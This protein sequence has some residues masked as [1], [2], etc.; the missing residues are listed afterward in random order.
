LA[1]LAGRAWIWLKWPAAVGILAWLYL[2]NQAAL[3]RVA[4]A[5][6]SWGYLGGAILLIYGS[7][8]LTFLRWYLLVRAQ[9]FPF[10]V[11]DAVRLGFLGLICNYVAPGSVGGDIFKA[12]LL[13]RSQQA[14]RAVAVA[15]VLLDRVLG[16]LAL[17]MVGSLATLLPLGIPDHHEL[18]FATLALW[19]GTLIGL[20]GMAFMLLPV[21]SRAR[22]VGRL[23][24]L[25]LVGHWLD[26]LIHGVELYQK[27]PLVL[28]QALV[29][30]LLGHAGLIAG[31]YLCG[32][33]MRQSWIPSLA[34]HYYFM[35]NAELFG[36][37]VPVPGGVG[38]LEGAIQWFYERLRPQTVSASE[39][40]AAGFMAAM[41]FRLVTVGIAAAG[42]GYYLTARQELARAIEESQGRD[43][44]A[45]SVR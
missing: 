3:A 32:L 20:A 40:M 37:L 27:R 13:A 8:L 2:S 28:A 45:Q 21:L 42:G 11:R 43:P 25:P 6:K 35:P 1:Q 5:P 33:W 38:A 15:T 23:T 10:L 26:E 9:D 31:F 41:A 12:L 17:F 7:T 22:W 36:V 4:A 18:R 30:S 14:R 44:A 19:A 34:A 39:A 24:R 16:L 29:L